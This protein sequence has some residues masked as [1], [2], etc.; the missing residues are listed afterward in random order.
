MMKTLIFALAAIL[1]CAVPAA[2]GPGPQ[3][4][5]S[6]FGILEDD[7]TGQ[8]SFRQTHTVP[9]K[10]GVKFGWMLRLEPSSGIV[11]WREEYTQPTAPRSW[12]PE[13]IGSRGVK[14]RISADG[15]TSVMDR[16]E[17]ISGGVIIS[18][19]QIAA[20]DPPGLH[21]IRVTLENGQ[22]AEF[23]FLVQE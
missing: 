3:I 14:R 7:G 16:E 10:P 20:G 21:I 15:R 18:A 23:K 5:E 17:R 19:W 11:R 4:V 9:L 12:G 6:V 2:A 1:L 13:Q 22:N 8:Q